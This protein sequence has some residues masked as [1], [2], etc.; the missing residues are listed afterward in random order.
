M[1]KLPQAS[2]KSKV[3]DCL[4]QWRSKMMMVLL[5]PLR[6]GSLWVGRVMNEKERRE[7]LQW[8]PIFPSLF[9]VLHHCSSKLGFAYADKKQWDSF[10]YR[11]DTLNTVDSLNDHKGT[12][13]QLVC[14]LLCQVKN[15]YLNLFDYFLLSTV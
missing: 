2:H 11:D 14:V 10:A 1:L 7:P 3:H 8:L 5:L 12:G 9:F 15:L 6:G 4:G 13:L